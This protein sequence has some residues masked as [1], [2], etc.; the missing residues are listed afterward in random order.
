MTSA[1]AQTSLTTTLTL[2]SLGGGS[3]GSFAVSHLPALG[4]DI[5]EV[6]SMAA[7]TQ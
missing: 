1:G 3:G 2:T 6:C 5:S 7:Y 4:Q